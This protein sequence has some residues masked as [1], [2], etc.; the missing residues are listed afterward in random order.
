MALPGQSF[1]HIVNPAKGFNN[2]NHL[3]YHAKLSSSVT[4]DLPAGRCCSLNSSG[5]LVT[6]VKGTA[7]PL[8]VFRGARSWDVDNTSN[9][10]WHAATP[11][12]YIKCLVATGGYE[13]ETTEYD[14]AQTYT[15]GD[16]LQ[17]VNANTTLATGGTL[18]NQSLGVLYHASSMEARVG[19]VSRGEVR[20]PNNLT[21]STKKVLA[22][23]PI[24]L[25]GTAA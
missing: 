9:D 17:A 14:D 1:D 7:M 3:D 16:H 11:R 18:T 5:E 25:P 10:E 22:F 15:P 2:S 8:W 19:V 12:G 23:W 6:G 13:L 21:D 4:F 20:H 24:Y